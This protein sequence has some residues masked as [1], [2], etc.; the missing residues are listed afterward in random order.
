MAENEAA[1]K[2]TKK[3]AKPAAKTVDGE[4]AVLAKIAAMPAPYRA[5][6][7]RLHALI[8][9]SAPALQPTTWYGMPG[10]AKDGKVV[11]F[12]RADTYMTFGLTDKANLT[13]EEGAPH[14]LL[15]SAWFFT[16]LDD[17][18]EAKLSAIVRNAAS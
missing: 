10:Y 9:R 3:A 8:L 14:Q 7:E 1:K 17:A 4:A 18:T 15:A 2:V 11:C 5:M 16:A 6:G 12:F 13:R